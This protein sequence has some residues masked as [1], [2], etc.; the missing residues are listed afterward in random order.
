VTL[1]LNWFPEAEHGGFFAAEVHG[2]FRDEGL[3]VEIQSGGPGAPV[4][5]QL[6]T[7]RCTLVVANADQVLLGRDQGAPIVAVMAAMQNSPHCIMVHRAAG[8]DSLLELRGV[9]L[10]VGAGK[11]F[12]KYLLHKLGAAQLNVVP[13]Q[14]NVGL[15]LQRADVAQQAY[16]F[17]EPFVAR[18]QGSDPQCLMLSEI[19]FNP[20][21]SVLVV[22]EQLIARDPELVRSVVRACVRGWQ[23]YLEEPQRTNQRIQEQNAEMSAEILAYGAREIRELC[24]PRGMNIAQ[25]GHMSAI[26]WK[27]LATQLDEIELL[28]HPDT[29]QQAFDSRFVSESE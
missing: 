1:A 14:G 9:T 19:G 16:V 24:V 13:Y 22:H 15:F 27:E 7:G 12:A 5:Q 4:I 2:Y 3:D 17:S 18:Q 29:W 11:P 23:K 28:D 8:I 20:Y 10:A 26:R 21:A 25:L 6:A